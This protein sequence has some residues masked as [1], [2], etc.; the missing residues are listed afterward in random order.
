M[1]TFHSKKLLL[2]AFA[3]ACMGIATDESRERVA[4]ALT[5]M[6]GEAA[7]PDVGFLNDSSHLQLS[8][9]TV[10]FPTV[11]ESELTEQA[12]IIASSALRNYDE[13]GRLDKITVLYREPVRK[14]MWWIRHTR[15]FS[16]DSL[17]SLPADTSESIRMPPYPYPR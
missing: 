9:L 4:D 2:A 14:G 11:S 5:R 8:L 3:V 13:A 7:D 15:T 6:L 1:R 17:L 16:V 10:A 12:R